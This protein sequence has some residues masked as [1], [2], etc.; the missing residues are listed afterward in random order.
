MLRSRLLLCAL[1]LTLLGADTFPTQG[2]STA[3]LRCDGETLIEAFSARPGY[4]A[5]AWV[6]VQRWCPSCRIHAGRYNARAPGNPDTLKAG[7]LIADIKALAAAQ[8]VTMKWLKE[9]RWE[10]V[11][12]HATTAEVGSVNHAEPCDVIHD[13]ATDSRWVATGGGSNG[14][15]LT[16]IAYDSGGHQSSNSHEGMLVLLRPGAV[17]GPEELALITYDQSDVTT[18][19]FLI[20]KVTVTNTGAPADQLQQTI[21]FGGGW[22]QAPSGGDH[23]QV[24]G[25]DL[26]GVSASCQPAGRAHN[27]DPFNTDWI[28]R[29]TNAL[30]DTYRNYAWARHMAPEPGCTLDYFT[31]TVW[32]WPNIMSRGFVNALVEGRNP[33]DLLPLPG[34]IGVTNDTSASPLNGCTAPYGNPQNLSTDLRIKAWRAWNLRRVHANLED[35]RL[36]ANDDVNLRGTFKDGWNMRWKSVAGNHSAHAPCYDEALE[37]SWDGAARECPGD[38]AY[39]GVAGWH[40]YEPG[41]YETAM[42]RAIVE[43]ANYFAGLAPPWN[44]VVSSIGDGPAHLDRKG[45]GL[46]ASTLSHP[47][48]RGVRA[49]NPNCKQWHDIN[50]PRIRAVNPGTSVEITDYKNAPAQWDILVDRTTDGPGQVDTWWVWCDKNDPIWQTDGTHDDTNTG[51]PLNF[52]GAPAFCDKTAGTYWIKAILKRGETEAEIRRKVIVQ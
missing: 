43:T 30:Y 19:H 36:G 2:F 44:V 11:Q 1:A 6:D 12:T 34:D 17:G 33:G 51:N 7:R 47:A 26:A 45:A 37:R 16:N 52:T 25:A 24:G 3:G 28:P 9:I 42:N 22:S 13:S 46:Q 29:W 14:I 48:W 18:P 23:V 32:P 21:S 40:D 20:E 5:Q 50:T 35:M 4:S 41:A 38:Q 39:D 49:G 27:V 15:T 8:G 31:P 10:I